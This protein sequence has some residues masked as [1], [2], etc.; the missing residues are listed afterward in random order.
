MS[1]HIQTDLF[2][3][4]SPVGAKPYASIGGLTVHLDKHCRCGSTI[5]VIVEGRGPHAAALQCP[6]CDLFFQWLP[7]KICEFLGS[8]LP[9]PDD[10]Q[11]RSRF[12]S[13]FVHQPTKESKNGHAKICRREFLESR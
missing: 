7:R 10:Q 11:S 1:K 8:W 3:E 2:G 9:A 5:F 13:K 4:V 12:M 6:R